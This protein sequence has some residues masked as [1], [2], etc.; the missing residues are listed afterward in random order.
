MTKK[1][2]AKKTAKKSLKF[3]A[4]KNDSDDTAIATKEDDADLAVAKMPGALGSTDED[5]QLHLLCQAILVSQVVPL[6]MGVTVK[7]WAIT[8][9]T[10][11]R[12]SMG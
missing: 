2:T 8:P 12:C 5:L 10:L 4:S 6:K 9:R 1:K 11:W 7:A 3:M